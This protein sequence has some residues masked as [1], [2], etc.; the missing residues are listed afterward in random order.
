MILQLRVTSFFCQCSMQ[1]FKKLPSHAP[2]LPKLPI[3]HSPSLTPRSRDHTT[4]TRS[5]PT[6][7]P[8]LPSSRNT[9]R[10]LD[11][12]ALLPN[13]I[14]QPGGSS[15]ALQVTCTTFEASGER[16]EPAEHERESE[17][18]PPIFGG[19]STSKPF[20]TIRSLAV[21]V[22]RSYVG[23]PSIARLCWCAVVIASRT[24]GLEAIRTGSGGNPQLC[25]RSCVREENPK[26]TSTLEFTTGFVACSPGSR[27]SSSRSVFFCHRRFFWKF[28]FAFGGVLSSVTFTSTL[29]CSSWC[30]SS[31]AAV[32]C[33][34][35][36]YASVSFFS[37]G[38]CN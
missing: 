35:D 20:T 6:F 32:C 10:E 31:S 4:N 11:S 18:S 23:S 37:R 29:W 19:A 27:R 1:F 22:V 28:L 2:Y 30:W 21:A 25:G 34:S 16:R 12:L 15:P 9:E 8:R 33:F 24:S 14:P 17:R 5:L 7:S 3:P 26:E 38:F 36:V 13:S